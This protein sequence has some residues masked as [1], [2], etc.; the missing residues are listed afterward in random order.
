MSVFS[1]Y[2]ISLH[3]DICVHTFGFVRLWMGQ[4]TLCMGEVMRMGF[5]SHPP[6]DWTGRV[7]MGPHGRLD[8]SLA[9]TEGPHTRGPLLG[10]R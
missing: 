1:E 6:H 5:P 7:S 10:S 2:L 9:Y 4:W 8:T 3:V